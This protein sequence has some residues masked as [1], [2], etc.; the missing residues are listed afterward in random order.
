MNVGLTGAMQA[1]PAREQ[2]TQHHLPDRRRIAGCSRKSKPTS[3]SFMK[4]HA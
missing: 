3:S 4:N 1:F 2:I